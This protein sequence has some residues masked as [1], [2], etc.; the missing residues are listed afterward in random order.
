M[1]GLLAGHRCANDFTAFS[2]SILNSFSALV[3]MTTMEIYS[4]VLCAFL[5]IFA[6]FNGMAAPSH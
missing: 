4:A 5:R 1:L 6:V 2:T 3:N